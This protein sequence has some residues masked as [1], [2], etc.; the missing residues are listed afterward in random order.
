MESPG[1]A[2]PS[3]P[4]SS[5]VHILTDVRAGI[6]RVEGIARSHHL[7]AAPSSRSLSPLYSLSLLMNF[8]SSAAG[9]SLHSGS[10]ELLSYAKQTAPADLNESEEIP[11]GLRHRVVIW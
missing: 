11:Q 1:A 8:R 9:F 7:S 4:S 2:S 10:E 3:S 6:I 5:S